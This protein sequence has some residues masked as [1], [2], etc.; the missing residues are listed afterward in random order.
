MKNFL[1]GKERRSARIKAK[2]KGSDVRPRLTVNRTSKHI[3]AQL[4]DDISGKVLASESDIKTVKSKVVKSERAKIVGKT[5]AEKA[6]K[7]K[8]AKAVFDRNGN[9]YHGRVKALADGA[10]EGGLKI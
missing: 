6:L 7:I 9:R 4:I 1:K 5:I 2:I 3:Y 10:R 8:I